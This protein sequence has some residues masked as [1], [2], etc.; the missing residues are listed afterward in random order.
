MKTALITKK[1]IS[2]LVILLIWIITIICVVSATL[3]TSVWAEVGKIPVYS[4]DTVRK[5]ISLTFNCAWD[6]KG[7]DELMKILDEENIRCTF[8]FVGSF[9]E[10]Y[11]EEVRKIYERGHEIAN[12]SMKHRDPVKQ[13]YGDIVS[14]IN[15]CNELLYSVTGERPTLYRAPS[16]SYDNKTVEAAMSLGMTAVQWDTDSLDWKDISSEKIISRVTDKA[17]NGSIV[18][19]HSGKDNTLEALPAIISSLKK[20]GYT[21]L[22]VS[23]MLLEGNTYQDAMGKQRVLS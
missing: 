10:N 15:S 19:F 20:E 7:I 13:E 1:D 14:D 5:E 16:G 17:T 4:V 8:F 18:L 22:C 2:L 9:A 6:N 23:E 21:F 11:P 12:H 3:Y